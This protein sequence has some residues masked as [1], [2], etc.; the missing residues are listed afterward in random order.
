LQY[1]DEETKYLD[2]PINLPRK[3]P[4][5]G[6]TPT[7]VAIFFRPPKGISA[8]TN[9]KDPLLGD[10]FYRFQGKTGMF[11][12]IYVTASTDTKDFIRNVQ[13]PY[14]E[15]DF[16]RGIEYKVSPKYREEPDSKNR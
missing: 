4:E 11:Q 5:S 10:V 15:V 14:P 1:F 8:T 3:P 13:R 16:S 2:E 6:K 7:D 12:E 9:P